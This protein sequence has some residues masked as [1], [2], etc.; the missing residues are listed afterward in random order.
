V[1]HLNEWIGKGSLTHL[2]VYTYK[3]SSN[4][5]SSVGLPTWPQAAI[6]WVYVGWL[7]VI[8]GV[9]KQTLKKQDQLQIVRR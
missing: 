5:R 4:T 9:T 1:T 3:D 8:M 6:L 2:D 7:L